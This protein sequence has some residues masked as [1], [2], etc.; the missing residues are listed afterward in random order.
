MYGPEFHP[1]LRLT[2]VFW[3]VRYLSKKKTLS[4]YI[5]IGLSFITELVDFIIN[6]IGSIYKG[7]VFK[8]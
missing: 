6:Y 4:N 2:M 7:F 3:F 5:Y 1:I 8:S